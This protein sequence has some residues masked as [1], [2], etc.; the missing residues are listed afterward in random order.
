MITCIVAVCSNDWGHYGKV[1]RTSNHKEIFEAYNWV[2]SICLKYVSLP[3][4]MVNSLM[5]GASEPCAWREFYKKQS[6]KP[7]HHTVFLCC[8]QRAGMSYWNNVLI[9]KYMH[10][11]KDIL[12]LGCRLEIS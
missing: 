2:V 6:W 11:S 8:H 12:I 7:F 5:R 4:I 10:F 1:L 9:E 3:C